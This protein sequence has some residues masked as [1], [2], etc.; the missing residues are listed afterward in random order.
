[1]SEDPYLYPA[2]SVLRNK[3]G[4]TDARRL[5]AF[6]RLMVAQRFDEGVPI[7]GFDLDH[8][9]TIHRHLF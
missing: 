6:E 1:M 7:G 8:L 2:T 3:L 4:L 9:R 5:E